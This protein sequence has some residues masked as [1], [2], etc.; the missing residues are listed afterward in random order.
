MGP[1]AI[2]RTL[3]MACSR[4]IPITHPNNSHIATESNIST[5]LDARLPRS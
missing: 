5:S 1:D 3:G 4:A 2:T